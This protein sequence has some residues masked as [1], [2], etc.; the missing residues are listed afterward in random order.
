[1][2]L[3]ANMMAQLI[4]AQ[5]DIFKGDAKDM[6]NSMGGSGGSDGS[7]GSGSSSGGNINSELDDILGTNKDP[8]ANKPSSGNGRDDGY[9]NPNCPVHGVKK[10]EKVCPHCGHTNCGCDFHNPPKQEDDPTGGL[11]GDEITPEN[12]DKLKELNDKDNE[13]QDAE[14]GD[15]SGGAGGSGGGGLPGQFMNMFSKAIDLQLQMAIPT[16][17][18]LNI[19]TSAGLLFIK[20]KTNG[21][22]YAIEIATK[23]MGYWAL[24]ITP[25]GIPVSGV[26]TTVIPVNHLSLVMPMAMDILALGK[27]AAVGGNYL[28]LCEVIVKYSKQC[29]WQV[30]EILPGTPPVTV[31]YTVN[32]T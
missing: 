29:V 13:R 12:F 24:C 31:P 8:N 6:A 1:M 3:D 14:N 19:K 16:T 18:N 26:I 2:P 25:T 20:P 30:V 10:K 4:T 9:V 22:L 23:I 7:N 27:N 17:P 21:V 28:P 15:G 5:Y 11:N 32:L